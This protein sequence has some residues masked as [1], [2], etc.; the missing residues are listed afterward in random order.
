MLTLQGSG[1]AL[2]RMP[3][4]RIAGASASPPVAIIKL[5]IQTSRV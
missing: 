5:T 1:A 3:G 2:G 4:R